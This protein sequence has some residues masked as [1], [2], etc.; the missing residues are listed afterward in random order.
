M[1]ATLFLGVVLV[2]CTAAPPIMLKP[3]GW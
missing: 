2:A 3:R 1:T